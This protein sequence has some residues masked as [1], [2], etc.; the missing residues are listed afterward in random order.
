MKKSIQSAYFT[1]SNNYDC[2]SLTDIDALI[3][4]LAF[5]PAKLTGKIER[6]YIWA[7]RSIHDI[8]QLIRLQESP[9]YKAYP[10]PQNINE[11][12]FNSLYNRFKIDKNLPVKVIVFDGE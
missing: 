7:F 4:K 5:R 6:C 12:K 2:L 1:L 9:Q 3:K 11:F 10:N 8:T